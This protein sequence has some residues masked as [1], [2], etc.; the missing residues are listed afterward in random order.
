MRIGRQHPIA[1]WLRCDANLYNQTMDRVLRLRDE[2]LKKGDQSSG[3]PSG[4][5]DWFVNEQLPNL[6]NNPYYRKQLE[7]HISD[8][9]AKSDQINKDRHKVVQADLEAQ[10]KIDETA[11]KFSEMLK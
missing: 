8:L 7:E 9:K 1:N 3:L 11:N 4:A 5:E 10:E 6:L 2:D